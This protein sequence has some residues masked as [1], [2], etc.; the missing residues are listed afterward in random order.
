MRRFPP[1]QSPGPLILAT[2][3]GHLPGSA[4]TS[5]PEGHTWRGLNP[6]YL[7]NL[8]RSGGTSPDP[9]RSPSISEEPEEE[10]RRSRCDSCSDQ[11][12]RV[13]PYQ[14]CRG[15]NNS[16]RSSMHRAPGT[17]G[18][19][20]RGREGKIK[21]GTSDTPVSVAQVKTPLRWRT[22]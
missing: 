19:G 17:Q 12:Q 1:S 6:S 9:R 4:P 2:T 5:S 18:Q 22:P 16:H 7:L 15:R 20:F 14:E 21:K 10:N 13:P 3:R 11:Q 8:R